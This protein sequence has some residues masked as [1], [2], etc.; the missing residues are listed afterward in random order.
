LCLGSRK[1][2]C[3]RGF[4]EGLDGRCGL[5]FRIGLLVGGRC[6]SRCKLRDIGSGSGIF[7]GFRRITRGRFPIID[8]NGGVC[9]SLQRVGFGSFGSVGRVNGVG[10]GHHGSGGEQFERQLWQFPNHAFN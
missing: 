5:I 8:R 9:S 2:I 1:Q 10:S 3:G 7:I 4:K 6:R